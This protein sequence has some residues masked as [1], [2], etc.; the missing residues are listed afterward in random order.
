MCHA[1]LQPGGRY[2][3]LR[4]SGDHQYHHQ[5]GDHPLYHQRHHAEPTVG[6][7]YSS[8]VNISAQYHAA[9]HRL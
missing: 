1:N 6:T 2:L 4:T 8:P 3:W 5:R 7:V 9:G